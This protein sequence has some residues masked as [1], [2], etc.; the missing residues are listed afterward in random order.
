MTNKKPVRTQRGAVGDR[1]VKRYLTGTLHADLTVFETLDHLRDELGTDRV[2]EI[3]ESLGMSEPSVSHSVR[4]MRI[5]HPDHPRA[6]GECCNHRHAQ[7]LILAEA[8]AHGPDELI[9][10]QWVRTEYRAAEAVPPPSADWSA[11]QLPDSAEPAASWPPQL[12]EPPHGWRRVVRIVAQALGVVCIAGLVVSVWLLTQTNAGS[13]VTLKTHT[14]KEPVSA[15]R[16]TVRERTSEH[17]PPA[18]QEQDELE[19]GNGLELEEQSNLP[20]MPP[21]TAAVAVPMVP[22]CKD[23]TARA[24]GSC[25]KSADDTISS[26]ARRHRQGE[27]AFRFAKRLAQRNSVRVPEWDLHEGTMHHRR[28]P[29]NCVLVFPANSK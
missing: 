21:A 16:T 2:R 9:D 12:P 26:V 1:L 27:S 13:L 18:I 6:A 24:S 25:Q 5:R 8:A 17:I 28:M 29:P 20:L 23:R 19:T 15:P 10:V 4:R 7:A 11:P 14:S 3:L 22:S